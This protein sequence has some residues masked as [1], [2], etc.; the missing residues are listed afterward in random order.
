MGG[1]RHVRHLARNIRDDIDGMVGQRNGV[2]IVW[3]VA[4]EIGIVQTRSDQMRCVLQLQG[5]APRVRAP[6]LIVADPALQKS[7]QRALRD[8]PEPLIGTNPIDLSERRNSQGVP[9]RYRSSVQQGGNRDY[10]LCD[11]IRVRKREVGGPGYKRFSVDIIQTGRNRQR[12]F[13]GIMFECIVLSHI[14][15][16]GERIEQSG[17]MS[18]RRRLIPNPAVIGQEGRHEKTV[19][20]DPPRTCVHFNPVR[21]PGILPS[22]HE[23]QLR[24]TRP[25]VHVRKTDDV[26]QGCAE[27]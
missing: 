14:R 8:T 17:V 23:E 16:S 18:Q 4:R 15:H 3:V 12:Q 1:G 11:S 10:G 13:V 2:G 26:E 19:I 20:V 9:R 22:L 5:R 7:I 21:L 24:L 6:H 25:D 27:F